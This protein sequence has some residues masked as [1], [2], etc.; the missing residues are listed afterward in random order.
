MYLYNQDRDASVATPNPQTDK[1]P[2]MAINRTVPTGTQIGLEIRT[3]GVKK[4]KPNIIVV[5]VSPVRRSKIPPEIIRVRNPTSW[6]ELGTCSCNLRR[7]EGV[8]LKPEERVGSLCGR[9]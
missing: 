3:K 5:S 9:P 4:I 7:N 1:N 8:V 2:A 6:V